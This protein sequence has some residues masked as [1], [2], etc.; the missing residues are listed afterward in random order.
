MYIYN[1]L[2]RS[3]VVGV[4]PFAPDRSIFK[5]PAQPS[6]PTKFTIPVSSSPAPSTYPTQPSA[7]RSTILASTPSL[8]LRPPSPQGLLFRDFWTTA[9][10]P[11]APTTHK[12]RPGGTAPLDFRIIVDPYNTTLY[13]V[14]THRGTVKTTPFKIKTA[15][16]AAV[17]PSS[18]ST[19]TGT[20]TTTTTTIRSVD[21][22]DQEYRDDETEDE[23]GTGY[24]DDN[25][26]EKTSTTSSTTAAP[27]PL[28]PS[29]HVR[30]SDDSRAKSGPS[31]QQVTVPAPTSKPV[32]ECRE[33]DEK[34]S[35]YGGLMLRVNTYYQKW[36]IHNTSSLA[37]VLSAS[38]NVSHDFIA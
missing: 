8:F 27:P 17:G 14:T 7:T 13:D 19:K 2:I 6:A 20:S 38:K 23:E 31:V 35:R 36:R 18:H 22:S 29:D 24:I 12:S 28:K 3:T 25:S 26:V 37:T 5:F 11:T 34:P 16:Q 15:P 21:Y 30:H 4:S 10:A 1:I 32:T 9:S 33:C